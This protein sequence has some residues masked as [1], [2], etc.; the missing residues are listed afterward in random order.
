MYTT[1]IVRA[2][3]V[4][5]AALAASVIAPA[6]AHAQHP[7]TVEVL[8]PVGAEVGGNVF[9]GHPVGEFGE[10]VDRGWGLSG[11]GNYFVQDDGWLGL[12]VD[13]GFM[14]YGNERIRECLTASC[15]VMVDVHTTYNVF[16]V[17]AGPQLAV[18]DGAIRP[19]VGGQA[20]VSFFTTQ[21]RVEGSDPNNDPFATSTNFSS[22][23]F[24]L[25]GYGGVKIPMSHGRTPV[26]LD[27]GA[28]FASNGEARYLTRDSFVEQDIGPPLIFPRRTEANYWM[29][30]V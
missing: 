30:Y 11:H 4:A 20:G 9:Y 25:F 29:F 2:A 16:M 24:A 26:S 13:F 6:Q 10:N 8:R 23:T 12:R 17:S 5:A 21:S 19:Y 1:F 7:T 15:R 27:L 22:S 14:N 18:P 3:G 28:R